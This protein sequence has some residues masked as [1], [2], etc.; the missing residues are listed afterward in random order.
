MDFK[1]EDLDLYELLEINISSSE[2]DIKKA[3]RK[4]A[5][6]CHPDKNPHDLEAPKKFHQ[7]TKILEILT[8]K[9]AK[10]AYDKVLLGKKESAIR[11]KELDSKRRKLKEDLESREQNA[12]SS[13]KKKSANEKLREQIE[14]LRKEGSKLVEEEINF[15]NKCAKENLKDLQDVNDHKIKIKWQASKND[16]K[17]GGYTKEILEKCMLKYGDI[18]ILILSSKK[19]GSAIIEFKD[20]HAAETAVN[21]EI[22][23]TSN[24]LKL[25]WIYGSPK[26]AQATSSL[27]KESDFESITLTRLRQAE[28][29]KRLIEEIIKDDQ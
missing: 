13:N 10:A 23:L 15:V 28:E 29:R 12:S 6:Q 5:L 16:P 14:R 21:Y 19:K 20:R 7:L 17:N 18:N 2:N 26:S 9:I 24:P 11:H 22:G 1:I 4:K 25:E 3:Y 8:D 27:I